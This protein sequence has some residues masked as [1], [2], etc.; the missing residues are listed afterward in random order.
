MGALGLMGI[1]VPEKYGGAGRDA[2]ACALTI[3]E[4]ARVDASHSTIVSVNN[5]LYCGATLAFGNE[6]QKRDFLLPVASG[7]QTG[8][9][10]LS[11]PSSAA[12]PAPW[13]A[14]PN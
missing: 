13:P 8:A 4:L 5:S 11:E 1:E 7:R 2:L 9:Y 3:E 10:S 6:E 12:T 14:A